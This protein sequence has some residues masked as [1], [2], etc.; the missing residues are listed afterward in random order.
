MKIDNC[1]IALQRLELS[2]FDYKETHEFSIIKVFRLLGNIDFGRFEL[3][4]L[5][6]ELTFFSGAFIDLGIDFDV[7]IESEAF[8]S[9]D[10]LINT[11]SIFEAQGV[12]ISDVGFVEERIFRI[13]HT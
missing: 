9:I 13:S 7:V 5:K 1:C 2:Y 12:D 11:I 10:T 6:T 3:G 8:F 4:D